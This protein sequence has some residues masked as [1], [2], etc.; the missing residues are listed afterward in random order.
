LSNTGSATMNW[1]VSETAT[2]LTLSATSGSLAGGASTNV[3]VSINANANSLAA[4]NY[5]DTVGFTNTTNG[6]GNTTRPVSL[7]V[8]A[9]NPAQLSVSPSSG[10]TS[11]GPVGGPFS[12]ASQLYTLSNTGSA[13][14]NWTVS[15]TATW[16]TLSATSGSLAAGG[17]T[18][19]TV[20]INA[21]ANSLA[22]GNYSDTVGFTNTT[23]GA[24]N[25]TR[26]VS[27]TASISS[28]GTLAYW[29]FDSS[30]PNPDVT[31]ANVTVAPV[32]VSNV[33][34][35]LTYFAGNPST[36]EAI[37]SSG[38]STLTGP[39][40]T[41]YSYFAFAVTATNGSQVNLSSIS[42]DDR[43][44]S[45]GPTA[46]DVQ[47]SQ[48][49]NFASVIYDSGAQTVHTAFTTTPMNTFALTNSGLTGTVYF[50]IYGYKAGGSGGTWR[51]DNLNIQG[52]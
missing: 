48:Q 41:N 47:I 29:S 9:L 44:S 26:A 8:S 30:T 15:K 5:S 10:L 31:G 36:G 49:A 4:G 3:T 20:S 32:T 16:L 24:G 46:F 7:T 28:S 52:R 35:S 39:P 27:L 12:P 22:A 1:T 43:A 2:W 34:G 19:V 45:T 6:A 11:S 37:A 33:G 18:N 23:N 17:G 42:F 14:M 21:N 50:R 51:L 25:T 40:A 13:T 38:F